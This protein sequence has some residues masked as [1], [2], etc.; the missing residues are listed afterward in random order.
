MGQKGQ[1]ASRRK[2]KAS[3]QCPVQGWSCQVGGI[4][5]GKARGGPGISD[6]SADGKMNPEGTMA[7][8]KVLIARDSNRWAGSC[9]QES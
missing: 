1:A 4:A 9:V 3:Q 8:Q 2:E 6:P 5:K 7:H